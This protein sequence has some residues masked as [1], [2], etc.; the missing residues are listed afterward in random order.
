M[1]NMTLRWWDIYACPTVFLTKK[2]SVWKKYDFFF[3]F[4]LVPK[5]INS[6]HSIFYD[7]KSI[8]KTFDPSLNF[9]K[10]VP[11][12]HLCDFWNG[13]S[14]F[15]TSFKRHEILYNNQ[16]ISPLSDV[17]HY[18]KILQWALIVRPHLLVRWRGPVSCNQSLEMSPSQRRVTAKVFVV[19]AQHFQT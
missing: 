14:Y 18:A 2:F 7:E 11:P 15:T 13:T 1:K 19:F 12:S 4:Y 6:L 8:L 3:N 10:F 9:S 5:L 17:R 16:S